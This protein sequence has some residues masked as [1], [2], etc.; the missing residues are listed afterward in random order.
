MVTHA[1]IFLDVRR[2]A[3]MNLTRGRHFPVMNQGLQEHPAGLVGQLQFS[4]LGRKIKT[5]THPVFLFLYSS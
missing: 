5:K 4:F 2:K 1:G 3:V